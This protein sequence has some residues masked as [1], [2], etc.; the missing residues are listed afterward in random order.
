MG[1][2]QYHFGVGLSMPQFKYENYISVFNKEF[3]S[4]DVRAAFDG[5]LVSLGD[6]D[7]RLIGDFFF[8]LTDGGKSTKSSRRIQI[9]PRIGWRQHLLD[10][11][12]GGLFIQ[13]LFGP[14]LNFNELE[15]GEGEPL[16]D[17]TNVGIQHVVELGGYYCF[18]EYAPCLA[19]TV[20]HRFEQN[21][22]PLP[23]QVN[24]LTFN[25][26]I[27]GSLFTVDKELYE[28]AKAERDELKATKTAL[29][30]ETRK[31]EEKIREL[32][33]K[34]YRQQAEIIEARAERD[35]REACKDPPL[36]YL[37]Y[38]FSEARNADLTAIKPDEA[39]KNILQTMRSRPNQKFLLRSHWF[40]ED[41]EEENNVMSLVY[42]QFAKN[43]L[44]SKGIKPER[45]IIDGKFDEMGGVDKSDMSI[46]GSSS[47]DYPNDVNT[48]SCQKHCV[49]FELLK[50]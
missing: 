3:H 2:Y 11:E 21:F 6:F 18:S 16:N 39:T 22:S 33:E 27:I 44:V 4:M 15:F 24:A 29:I 25:L 31:L 38:V 5:R 48:S 41:T 50:P 37:T 14:A 32:E 26:G 9:S 12:K 49:V 34:S 13:G 10:R 47:L 30:N 1:K 45:L 7:G 35:K 28:G 36:N 17:N 46:K 23:Y 42:A 8:S 43:Y 20:G 19:I 40:T